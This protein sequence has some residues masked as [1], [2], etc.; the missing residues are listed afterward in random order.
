MSVATEPLVTVEEMVLTRA[1]QIINEYGIDDFEAVFLAN[2][3]VDRLLSSV[4][5]IDVV[6]N[7]KNAVPNP[8]YARPELAEYLNNGVIE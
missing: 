3:A 4:V 5:D 8:R 2:N 7:L 6:N 1:Q